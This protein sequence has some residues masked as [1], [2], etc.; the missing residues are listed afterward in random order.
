VNGPLVRR[1][2]PGEV[3]AAA[4]IEARAYHEGYTVTVTGR[5]VTAN[6]LARYL[7]VE[8]GGALVGVAGMWCIVDQAHVI[9]VAVE[10]EQ[11]RRGYGRLLVHG[12]ILLAL[13]EGME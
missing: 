2:A 6:R 9:T 13:A 11:R 7:V 3:D 1:I 12:L 5:E 10:P 8:Q 4:A